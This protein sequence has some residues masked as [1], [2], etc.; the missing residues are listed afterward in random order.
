MI[1]NLLAGVSQS[2]DFGSTYGYVEVFQPGGTAPIYIDT[3]TA[4]GGAVGTIEIPPNSQPKMLRYDDI[5]IIHAICSVNAK[6]SITPKKKWPGTRRRILTIDTVSVFDFPELCESF[7]ITNLDETND[8]YFALDRDPDSAEEWTRKVPS[9]SCYAPTQKTECYSIRVISSAA[10][11]VEV[12]GYPKADP[13]KRSFN[14][15]R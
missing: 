9:F 7:E 12:T 5:Q 3:K 2:V 10:I 1:L 15:R 11:E 14:T 8:A 13:L 6:V 4:V